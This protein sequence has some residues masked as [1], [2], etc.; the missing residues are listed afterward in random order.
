[1]DPV[2]KE[3]EQLLS[4]YQ[5]TMEKFLDEN[6]QKQRKLID[7]STRLLKELTNLCRTLSQAQEEIIRSNQLTV[8]ISSDNLDEVLKV[9]VDHYQAMTNS[10][11]EPN[12]NKRKQN[13]M[14]SL[15][16]R[17]V[18]DKIKKSRR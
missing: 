16:L 8:N 11:M 15:K 5:M 18:Q 13:E 12:D 1:M 2:F 10:S 9:L 3:L 7:M 4:Q 14:F 17:Y 6:K